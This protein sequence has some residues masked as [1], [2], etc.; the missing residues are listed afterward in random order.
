MDNLRRDVAV[1]SAG[2]LLRSDY[3]KKMQAR[4]GCF[5]YPANWNDQSFAE[6]F[7]PNLTEWIS[8]NARNYQVAMTLSQWTSQLIPNLQ[9]VG[10]YYIYSDTGQLTQSEA[11]A[12]VLFYRDNSQ[13]WS[14]SPDITTREHF[15]RLLYNLSVFYSKHHQLVLA[16]KYNRDAAAADPTNVELLLGCLKM[17]ILAKQPEDQSRFAAAIE[18]LDP[19]NERLEQVLKSALAAAQ[20]DNHGT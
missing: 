19:G 12:S 5:W 13:L 8:Q 20:D 11:A 16:A 4:W 14:N 18:Q 10:F 7:Q 1:V 2:A 17:A 3:R 9:P 6:D 15:G